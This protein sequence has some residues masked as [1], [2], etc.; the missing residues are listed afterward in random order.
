MSQTNK[1]YNTDC[2]EAMKY[3]DDEDDEIVLSINEFCKWDIT[4]NIQEL[5]KQYER[6]KEDLSLNSKNINESR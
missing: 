5:W 3:I 6:I 2:I 4:L 1:L